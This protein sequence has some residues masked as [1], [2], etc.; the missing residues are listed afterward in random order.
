MADTALA[1]GSED[2][3]QEERL[4]KLV[5]DGVTSPN[6]RRAY[7]T[8]L[9]HFFQWVKGH[10]TRPAFSKALVQEYKSHLQS[11]NLSAATIN[12]RLSTL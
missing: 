6:S 12:L 4:I 10:E 1:P 5:M 11:R 7:R 3:F 9:T 8:G 2:T